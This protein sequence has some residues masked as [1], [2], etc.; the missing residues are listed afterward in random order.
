MANSIYLNYNRNPKDEDLIKALGLTA[1]LMRA[2]NDLRNVI[3]PRFL[4]ALQTLD[5]SD[6]LVAALI[7]DNVFDWAP[8]TPML[9]INLEGDGVVSP[10]NT[11]NA[12]NAMRKRGVASS[13]MRRSI[14]RDS[15]LNHVTAVP[16]A[17]SR[18]R[19]FFDGGFGA[20]PD[21]Q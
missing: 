7:N 11:I 12:Y 9:L 8:K 2:K 16:A 18:A 19:A 1:I 3:T 15:A 6:P 5:R 4:K 21:A 13:S 10:Q 20:V 17:M 14:I